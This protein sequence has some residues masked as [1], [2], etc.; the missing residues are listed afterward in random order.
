MSAPPP[1]RWISETQVLHELER[2]SD[3]SMDKVTEYGTASQEAA[4]AEADY[5]RDRAKAILSFKAQATGARPS[6]AEAELQADASEGVADAYLARLLT[7]AKS[8]SLKEAMRSIRANQE[9]LR[10][11]AASARDGVVGPGWSGKR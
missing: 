10:T 5:K 6:V 2:L 7:A 8:D 11:A 9:A 1:R 3:L 4:R